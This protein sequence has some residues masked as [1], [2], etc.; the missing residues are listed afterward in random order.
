MLYQTLKAMGAPIS[1]AGAV[2]A[3]QSAIASWAAEP[4]SA[5]VGWGS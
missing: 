5:I 1:G 2:F 3:D 4:V